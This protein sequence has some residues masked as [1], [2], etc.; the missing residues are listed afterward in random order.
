MEDV[1]FCHPTW[2]AKSFVETIWGLKPIRTLYTG[3]GEEDPMDDYGMTDVL[4]THEVV[5]DPS[6][7]PMVDIP[8]E[9]Y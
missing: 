2:R 4:Q 1:E 6:I 8:W 5:G 9:E 7:C 3:E